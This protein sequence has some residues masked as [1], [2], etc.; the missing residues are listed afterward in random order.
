MIEPKETKEFKNLK[1]KITLADCFDILPLIPDRSIDLILIDPPY[2][3]VISEDFDKQWKNILDYQSFVE[4]LA[5]QFRR[6]LKTNGSFLCFTDGNNNAYSQVIYD[7]Y[8]NLLNLL[9]FYKTDGQHNQAISTSKGRLRKFA[10]SYESCLFYQTE[11]E[12][13]DCDNIDKDCKLLKTMKELRQ[14]VEQKT[15]QPIT[16]IDGLKFMYKHYFTFSQFMFIKEDLF[17]KLINII[18]NNFDY[19]YK[20]LMEEYEKQ[21]QKEKN[22][23]R[24]FNDYNDNMADCQRWSWVNQIQKDGIIHPT[25][26]PLTLIKELIQKTSKENDLVLDC[27]SG[28]GATAIACYE[29]NRN[30]I[31]IEKDEK[32][33]NLSMERLNNY[34]AEPSLFGSLGSEKSC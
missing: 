25:Q 2:Y 9:I 23:Q 3:K 28:S 15:N 20:E 17:N 6:I 33:H 27:F 18:G 13:I 32:Y 14:K 8:F 1:N 7:K 11:E 16:K 10:N 31:A 34:M 19:T 21:K 5:I 22:K 4:Q 26:K 30:F 29:L 12:R 24:H